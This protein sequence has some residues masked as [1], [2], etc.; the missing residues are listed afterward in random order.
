MRRFPTPPILTCP[1]WDALPPKARPV[2]TDRPDKIVFHHTAGHVPDIKPRLNERYRSAIE[3]AQALQRYH[4]LTNGWNDSGHN[5]LVTRAGVIV[6]GR[7]G[8]V[9]AIE[10]G[11]M[12]VS[13]HCPGQNNNPGIEH[14]H[15]AGELMT[16]EQINATVLLM[17]W[18][19]NR[20][21]IR[22]TEIYPHSLFYNTDCPDNLV[23][24]IKDIR[25]RVARYLTKCGTEA[26]VK[27]SAIATRIA[28]R[29]NVMI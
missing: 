27:S 24:A 14:E 10:H 15:I 9:I 4:M 21:G 23:N 26:P 6:Q 5:F 20:T 13:A 28:I 1:N 8:S 16:Q 25:L 17:T 18:I 19:C 7:W 12:V 2:V 3:Y 11:R 22:P 29:R